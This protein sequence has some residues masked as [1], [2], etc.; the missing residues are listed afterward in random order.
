MCF[1]P[2]GGAVFHQDDFEREPMVVPGFAKVE[3]V[4]NHREMIQEI[5][6]V[7]SSFHDELIGLTVSSKEGCIFIWP[8]GWCA[9]DEAKMLAELLRAQ[10]TEAALFKGAGPRRDFSIQG[11]FRGIDGSVLCL[12]VASSVAQRD[13]KD[14]DDGESDSKEV[15][16]EEEEDDDD[17]DDEA[18]PFSSG[19]R[20]TWQ[21]RTTALT[22]CRR[23][24][25]T[26]LMR[27]SWLSSL[28]RSNRA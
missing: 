7:V 26:T 10:T 1:P 12:E 3:N 17:D 24:L 13:D 27:S 21:P 22:G 9:F 8:V 18:V 15:I 19:W 5:R 4:E 2:G 6:Q 16:Q 25:T 14:S 11:R 20:A 23:E 28:G